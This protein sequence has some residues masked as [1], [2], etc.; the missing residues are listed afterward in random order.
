L[1]F[2]Q[3]RAFDLAMGYVFS[4]ISDLHVRLPRAGLYLLL[5]ASDAPLGPFYNEHRDRRD[6]L[7]LS[8]IEPAVQGACLDRSPEVIWDDG[9][10][11]PDYL[12]P[13]ARWMKKR[14]RV[15]F[16]ARS[17]SRI[18]LDL[19][20]HLP[21]LMPGGVEVE[22]WLNGARICAFTLFRHGWLEL[23]IELPETLSGVEVFELELRANRTW[24]PRP[25]DREN[26]DDRNLSIAVCNLVCG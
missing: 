10:Y 24:E 3:R 9:W 14:A 17:L 12:P 25:G 16:Q 18:S 19:T 26:R 20:T 11:E 6:L 1:N 21:D 5:K 23:K 22:L 15:Q 2:E 8:R 7:E 4:K 13:I